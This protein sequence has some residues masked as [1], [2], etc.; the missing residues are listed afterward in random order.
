MGLGYATENPSREEVDVLAGPVVVQ[1]G[2]DWCG[3]CIA[4]ERHIKP[5]L[6]AAPGVQHL[7]VEDGK[8]YPLGRSFR[9]KLWPTLVFLRDGEEVARVVRPTRRA[10]IDDALAKLG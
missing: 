9:V 5:A 7:K 3:Y 2:T 1:F 6:E 4:A 8:G 10:E